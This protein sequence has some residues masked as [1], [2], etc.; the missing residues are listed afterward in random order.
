MTAR[1]REACEPRAGRRRAGQHAEALPVVAG[2][3]GEDQLT[4]EPR[5]VRR[6]ARRHASGG[7][8]VAGIG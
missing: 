3:R 1:Q 5:R 2:R 8:N 4:A 7:E 6:C